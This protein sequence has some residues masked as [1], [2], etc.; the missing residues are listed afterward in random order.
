MMSAKETALHAA[1]EAA[2]GSCARGDTDGLSDRDFLIVDDDL[3]V[4]RARAAA[5]KADGL[6][7]ASYTFRKLENLAGRGALFIQHLRLEASISADRDGRLAALLATFCPKDGY[8]PELKDNARLASLIA[9]VPAGSLF[10]LWAADVL[11]VTVRNFGVLWLAGRGK[12]VFAY[13]RILEALYEEGM[14]DARGVADLRQLRF[15]KSLYRGDHTGTIGVVRQK[16]RAALAGLPRDHF[17]ANLRIV[18]AEEVLAAPAPPVGAPSYIILRDLEKRMLAARFLLG[19]TF[20]D[21]ALAA[22]NGW[23]RDPRVYANLSA[24][25]APA[26]RDKLTALTECRCQV[27]VG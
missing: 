23:V 1:S 24:R 26:L 22:L 13:D 15:L 2:F 8:E 11:Y 4:L 7:V 27:L 9:T 3:E 5:L 12:Y 6:S 19:G 25:R 16:V 14:L 10:E 17:P 20:D 18:S 21:P